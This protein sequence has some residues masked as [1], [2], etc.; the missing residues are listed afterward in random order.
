[1]NQLRQ[2]KNNV[3][4]IGTLKSKELELKSSTDGKKF[5]SGKL[6][7][8]SIIDGKVHDYVI[9]IFI[10]ESSKLYRGIETVRNEY[11]T[12]DEHGRE[13]ADRIKVKGMLKLKEFYN[14][15]GNLVQYNEIRGMIFNRLTE[16]N[17][18]EDVALASIETI[19]ERF[20]PVL[21]EGF[22]TNE[23]SVKGFTV[24]W[25]GEVI[26]LKDVFVGK[27]IAQTFM[28]LYQPGSTGKLSFKLH[29]YSNE[30]VKS[31]T[32][33]GFGTTIDIEDTFESTKNVWKIEV[34][35]GDLPYVGTIEYTPEEIEQAKKVRACKLSELENKNRSVTIPHNNGFGQGAQ[36]RNVKLT[37]K[38]SSNY[39]PV[40]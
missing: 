33:V 32:S 36:T 28:D 24:G 30:K 27:E 40:F 18:Q 9:E 1:M 2:L 11:K 20:E 34:I 17:D 23:Y 15:H 6:I 12:I 5:M 35:G 22:P 25:K 13:N 7:V 4:V 21:K 38:Y 16:I 19:V 39:T 3:E 29:R 26:V 8:Q 10:M 37:D 14:N 31:D